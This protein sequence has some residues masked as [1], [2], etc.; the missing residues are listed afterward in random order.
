MSDIS[1]ISVLTPV[2]RGADGLSCLARET[3]RA[4][5]HRHAGAAITVRVLSESTGDPPLDLAV[6]V[7]GADGGRV[8][9]VAGAAA[10]T[11][12]GPS[13]DLAVMLHLHLAPVAWPFVVRQVPLAAVLVGIEAWR[14][15]GRITAALLDRAAAVVAIS[16]YTA[17][18]FRRHN[19][20]WTEREIAVCH[21]PVPPLLQAD[22]VAPV[23]RDPPYALMVGRMSADERYKGHDRLIE[24]WA[25]VRHA[26]GTAR[27]VVVGGGDDEA[28]LREKAAALG[29]GEAVTFTGRVSDGALAA[30][31]RDCAFFVLPSSS[32]GFGFVFLEAMA[33][34]KPCLGAPG[35]AEEIIASG[36]SGLIVDPA[37]DDLVDA[38]IRLFTDDRVRT[39]MGEEARRTAPRFTS[40]R[41]AAE[42][43]VALRC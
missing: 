3:V 36:V 12:I 37:A 22:A 14:P 8:R 25:R 13:P 43:D 26:A 38:L 6:R 7:L 32:E 15:I 10:S 28:R 16:A 5:A 35:A 24:V 1:R 4:L 18:E 11:L 21:P 40:A 19:P 27:L 29:L 41:F 30:L 31:Y 39:A 2:F 34:G 9:Y 20:A 42:L 23:P 33:R 17:R